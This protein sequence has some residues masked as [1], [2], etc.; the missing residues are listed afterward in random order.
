MQLFVEVLLNC[1]EEPR[2]VVDLRAAEARLQAQV[3]SLQS[4]LDGP[5]HQAALSAYRQSEVTSL[6]WHA[7]HTSSNL[8]TLTMSSCAS[9]A[10]SCLMHVP[11][12]HR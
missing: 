4:R 9:E 7:V 2:E 5:E 8:W 6:C 12:G 11:F 10:C 1:N 3:D